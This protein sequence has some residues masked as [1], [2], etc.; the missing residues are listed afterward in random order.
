MVFV[1]IESLDISPTVNILMCCYQDDCSSLLS[2]QVSLV[3]GNFDVSLYQESNTWLL[4][5]Y[6][7]E[8]SNLI[9]ACCPETYSFYLAKLVLRRRTGMLMNM[10]TAPAVCL[11]LI[12]PS[13]F[14]LPTGSTGK[15]ILGVSRWTK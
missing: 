8:V 12:L 1:I 6:S 14:L 4:A 10:Y 3:R 13:I 5:N 2:L 9:Y 7:H 11:S 15:I